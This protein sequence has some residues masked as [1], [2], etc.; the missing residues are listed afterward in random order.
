MNEKDLL[1]Q[2]NSLKE[3]KPSPDF[4]KMNREVLLTQVAN[5]K[6]AEKLI[7]FN[8]VR[9]VFID[10]PSQAFEK[11]SQPAVAVVLVV[12]CVLGSGIASM[13]AAQ[14]TKP[15][16]SLYIAKIASEKTQFV[17]AWDDK[18]K[19]ELGLEFAGNRAKELAEVL[20]ESG[21]SEGAKDEVVEKLKNDFKKELS[22]AK[23]RITK[24]STDAK[25][26]EAAQADEKSAADS[27][28]DGNAEEDN[29]VFSANLEKDNKGLQTSEGVAEVQQPLEKKP[30]TGAVKAVKE[31]PTSTPAIVP[32]VATGTE[33]VLKTIDTNELLE[34]AK[35]LLSNKDYDATLSKL[36][37]AGAGIDGASED[38]IVKGA[39]EDA[40]EKAVDSNKAENASSTIK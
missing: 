25:N 1:G 3:I 5:A 30:E 27:K 32:G 11:I 24:I 38:V 6:S 2:L 33:T 21:E 39:S 19:A 13:R 29:A 7:D 28:T 14:N 34:Q 35:M 20:A 36:D 40:S 23:G 17:L 16:D 15:G 8:W 10:L 9:S 18:K 37:E 22:V 12:V 4:K 26:D 31:A